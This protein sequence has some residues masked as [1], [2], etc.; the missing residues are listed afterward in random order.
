QP[1]V[2]S[3]ISLPFSFSAAAHSGALRF[4]LHDALPILRL[5]HPLIGLTLAG[6]ALSGA[7]DLFQGL[8]PAIDTAVFAACVSVGVAHRRVDRDRK[9]TRLHSSHVKISY[10]DFCLKKKEVKTLARAV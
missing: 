6:A 3:P 7:L 2:P 1:H 10:A 5:A 9:S 4:S 8:P